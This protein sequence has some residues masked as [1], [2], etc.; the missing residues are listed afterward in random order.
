[1]ADDQNTDDSSEFTE[2][3]P[4]QAPRPPKNRVVKLLLYTLAFLVILAVLV[5][6]VVG[7]AFYYAK[8]AFEAD[9]PRAALGSEETI[10]TL[11]RGKGLSA[12]AD[13]LESLGIISN[14]LIFQL[15]VRFYEGQSDLKAGEYA[16][17]SGASMQ[18]V[19]DIL[20]DGKSILY[21]LTIPEG[22]TTAQAMRL[23]AADETL[24]GDMPEELPKEGDL[25]PET[26]LFQRGT[27]RTEF[28]TMMTDAHDKVLAELWEGR[29][30][31]LPIKT[32]EDA[33]ILASI[34]E[35]ETG[36]AEERPM[37]AGVFINRLNR[38]MRLESDPTII[39]GL[40]GGEPLGRG[41]RQSE[42]KKP[43]P[44]NTYQIDGLPPTPIANPGRD[45]LAAVLNPPETKAL[46]FVADGTG[47]HVFATTYSEHRRNVAAW[48]RIEK[49][50]KRQGNK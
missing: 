15:G 50:R 45:A 19:M 47:G 14:S 37:V 10:Y 3:Q 31:N 30:D 24:L 5:G 44:Y 4:E 35:K 12:I 49:E 20:R 27:T 13:D 23:V 21:K 9:G 41:L 36:L 18:E 33:V 40:T 16:I 48:R 11:E 1:M 32:P 25:L 43:N 22:L 29:A 42:L 26:Y 46:Y 34:V 17:P 7:G 8:E 2:S 6:G 38:P 28:I 39:Y